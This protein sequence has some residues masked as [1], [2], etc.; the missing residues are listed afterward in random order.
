[1]SSVTYVEWVVS[2]RFHLLSK[3][4]QLITPLQLYVN[5]KVTATLYAK[6]MSRTLRHVS[7]VD[8]LGIGDFFDSDTFDAHRIFA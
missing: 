2:I 6:G 8:G 4:S 3:G 5:A 1:M 7:S